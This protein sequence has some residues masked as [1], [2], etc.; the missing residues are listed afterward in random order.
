VSW[1]SSFKYLGPGIVI[2]A[3]GVGAGDLI[4]ASV[5]GAK[6]STIILWSAV[7]GAIL[8]YVL[9]EGI[10]RWQ[11]GSN[12]SIIEAWVRRFPKWISW[13]FLAFL[14]LWTFIVGAA[15]SSA[16]GMAAHAIFPFLS[17]KT[18]AVIHAV[19][20][21]VLIRFIKY[22]AFENLMKALIAIM[23]AI[24]FYTAIQTSPDWSEIFKG[25]FI[26]KIPKGSIWII[27]G[28]IGG[29]GGSLTLLSYGYWIKEKGWNSQ[30]DF[31]KV[32]IDLGVAYF[33]TGLFGVA[34]MVISSQLKVEAMTG[35][36]MVLSLSDQIASSSGETGKWI[37]LLGFWGA[38]FSSMLGVWQGVPYLF[39]DF[40][41]ARQ[42]Q[43][44]QSAS[45]SFLLKKDS[46]YFYFQIYLVFAPLILLFF[47]KPVWIIITYA[48]IGSLFMPFLAASLLYLN[49]F[50]NK[51]F[52]NNWLMVLLLI[53]SMVLFLVLFGIKIIKFI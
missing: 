48:V 38:V 24:V 30:K 29:V 49:S 40:M 18:W 22:Q 34:M 8:K 1:R 35:N 25:L 7:L 11:M 36:Q 28:I 23:F 41:Q 27:L 39:S 31:K 5:G 16:S 10:A 13:Y 12:E 47:Q 50:V 51:V 19:F 14:I 32:K 45:T 33:L 4:A 2:A 26:P 3:T 42:T 52:R 46:W 44:S 9:N 6:F 43:K 37:F 21:F 17:V 20:A 53:I 15:L